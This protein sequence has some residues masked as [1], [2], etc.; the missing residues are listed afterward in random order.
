MIERP[1]SMINPA[2]FLT[3]ILVLATLIVIKALA[4]SLSAIDLLTGR[5]AIS[6]D[7]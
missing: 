2:V 7:D 4:A 3:A 1:L 6:D 5:T